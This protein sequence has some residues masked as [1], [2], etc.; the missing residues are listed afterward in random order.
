MRYDFLS[1]AFVLSLF[2]VV[3]AADAIKTESSPPPVVAP[4]DGYAYSRYLANMYVRYHLSPPNAPFVGA[5]APLVPADTGD[6]GFD[7]EGRPKWFDGGDSWQRL[8]DLPPSLFER[9][10]FDDLDQLFEDWSGPNQRIA[11]GTLKLMTFPKTMSGRFSVGYWQEN[12]QIIRRWREKK[13]K[14]AAAAITEAVYWQAYAWNARGEGYAR[15]VS[16]DGWRLFRERMAKAEAVLLESKAYAA[17]NP[18]WYNKY[19]AVLIESGAPMQRALDVLKEAVEK[20]QECSQNYTVIAMHHA[21]KW[22]GSWKMVEDFANESTEQ[23][24]GTF[25]S[26]LYAWIYLRVFYNNVGEVDLF[27][28]TLASWPKMKR[29]IEEQNAR[30]PYSVWAL[31]EFAGMACVAGDADAYRKLMTRIGTNLQRQAWPHNHSPD[32][33]ANKFSATSRPLELPR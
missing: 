18:V 14:S 5:I 3:S 26:M 7:A 23:T 16:E 24:R 25:G 6:G 4:N 17:N 22:G 15:S 12:G 30:Y 27:R 20:K 19:I 10:Q 11:N 29:G 9:E 33:C 13:P 2:P 21:P 1:L 28:D 8:A 32:L 31:N